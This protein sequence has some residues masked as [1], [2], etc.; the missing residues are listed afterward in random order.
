MKNANEIIAIVKANKLAEEI[1]KQKEYEEKISKSMA[2][3]LEKI[4]IVDNFVEQKLIEG[5]GKMKIQLEP[6][7]YLGEESGFYN[8]VNFRYNDNG[9]LYYSYEHDYTLPAIPI[10]IY[11]EYLIQHGFKVEKKD[12]GKKIAYSSTG[13]TS[14]SLRDICLIIST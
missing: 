4:Q 7:P 1:A 5:K 2:N 14:C 10:D 12:N 11:T 9:T 6:F 8:L 13:K 3:Y